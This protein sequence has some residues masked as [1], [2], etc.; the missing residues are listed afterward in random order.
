MSGALAGIARE[1]SV[2]VGILLF[3]DVEVLDFAG[4]FEVFSVAAR[5]ALRGGGHAPFLISMIASDKT[6]LARHG[7]VVGATAN[8]SDHP[9]LDLL[10]VPGGVVTQAMMD[11]G[12]LDW[13]S[14]TSAKAMVTA[15]VCTGAFLLARAGLLDGRTVTTHWE[16]I[17]ELRAAFPKLTV[18]TD[19]PFV[20]GGDII[21]SAGISAGIEMSLHLVG[22]ILGPGAAKRT[23]R[24][25]QYRW[26]KA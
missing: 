12:I 13:I 21:T 4:P 26:D 8:L 7:L 2:Q 11:Q 22:G 1:R 16:D 5:L 3:A 9:P 10:I 17:D 23:A 24:Q 15:S 20:D 18:V 14:A 6:V 19:V 25:M